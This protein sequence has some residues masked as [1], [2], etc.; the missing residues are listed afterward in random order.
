MEAYKADV[1][2][3]EGENDAWVFEWYPR[4]HHPLFCSE[5]GDHTGPRRRDDRRMK[6]YYDELPQEIRDLLDGTEVP[7]AP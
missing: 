3:R 6:F 7:A 1:E 4:S 5:K 2:W